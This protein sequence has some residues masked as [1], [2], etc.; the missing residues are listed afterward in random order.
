[1]VGWAGMRGAVSLAASLALPQ[2]FPHRDLLVFLTFAVIV[3]T[4]VGQGLTLPPLIRRLGLVTRDE[5]AAVLVAETRRRLPVM[6]L[7]R[8]EELT[9]NERFPDEVVDRIR[10]G[11]EAQLARLDR[12]LVALG[13]RDGDGED[14]DGANGDGANGPPAGTRGHLEAEQELRKLVI[15]TERTELDQLLA[16][17]KVTEPVADGVRAALDIDETTM[18]P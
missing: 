2:S 5:Q 15:A 6:A 10:I 3:A 13:S 16:R 9:A 17:R 18:R 4:L 14:G 11:Y 1:M 8:L 7:A 12:R